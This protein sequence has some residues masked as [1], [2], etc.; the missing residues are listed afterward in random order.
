MLASETR[1]LPMGQ[2]LRAPNDFRYQISMF[3]DVLQP[4]ME[5]NPVASML[6]CLDFSAL[7]TI[8]VILTLLDSYF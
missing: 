6:T 5:N 2:F 4:K 7:Q 8:N 3:F 1:P